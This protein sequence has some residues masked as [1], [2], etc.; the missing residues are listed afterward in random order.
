MQNLLHELMAITAPPWILVT[1]RRH[2]LRSLCIETGGTTGMIDFS[3]RF[4]MFNHLGG[5][6]DPTDKKSVQ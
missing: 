4:D 2:L 5:N 6:W 1:V 3:I